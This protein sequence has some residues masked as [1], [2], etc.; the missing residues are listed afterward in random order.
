MTIAKQIITLEF[1]IDIDRVP[2]PEHWDWDELTKQLEGAARV[3]V[4]ATGAPEFPPE[5]KP[6]P[7]ETPSQTIARRLFGGA[8]LDATDPN[9]E[10]RN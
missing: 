7:A 3:R 1:T 8:E 10:G 2:L 5:P 4:L 9:N 6:A